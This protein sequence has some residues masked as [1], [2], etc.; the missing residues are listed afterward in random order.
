MKIAID[1][2]NIGRG[3]TGDE[4]VFF[5]LVKQFA[6]LDA[7][8]NYLLLTDRKVE[9]DSLLQESLESL[10][11][12]S[13]F[14]VVSLGE[15]GVNKFFWNAWI[16]PKYL[17][18][19][20]VDIF[21]TQY[22]TPFFVPKKIKIVTIVHDVSFRV[23][24]KLIRTI[25]LF[26]LKILM[27][28]S[29]RRADKII[30]VSRFTVSE[31]K[32]Y[33]PIK[34]EK[35]EWIYNAVADNFAVDI[36][37]EQL[38][39]VRK[40][41]NLPQK[42][43]LSIGTFQPRKNLPALIEAYIKIPT[44]KR[45]GLKLVLAGGRGR[46]YDAQIDEFI[47]DYSLQSEVLLP[48]FIAEADKP[49]LFKLT[50]T[51]C[52]PSIYEGFGI[53]I[54]EAMTLGVPTLASNIEPHLEII[55]NSALLFDVNNSADFSEKLTRI[56]SDEYLRADLAQKELQQTTKFSWRNTAQKMLAIYGKIISA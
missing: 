15:S 37:P 50:H 36:S 28:M 21:Q 30:G 8:N 14:S 13:N 54:L 56:V 40:K 10:D 39:A 11:L 19:H 49:A 3:R 48:G 25:D 51:F 9:G 43:I 27:P 4:V 42:F 46:N 7:D 33:Y 18:A 45:A 6:L 38:E 17:R 29:L 12:P 47:K 23:F 32:K 5:N 53:P 34:E 35:L 1:I 2:R 22:I 41:Y 55:E 31:V 26:F 52:F 20:P 24:P 16:L 44:E